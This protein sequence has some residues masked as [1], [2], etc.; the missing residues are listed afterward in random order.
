MKLKSM[1][2]CVTSARDSGNLSF[3]VFLS[4]VNLLIMFDSILAPILHCTDEVTEPEA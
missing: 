4:F 1:Y 3:T 2:A